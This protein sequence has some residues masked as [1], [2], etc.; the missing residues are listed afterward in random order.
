M[1]FS[2]Y[3]YLIFWKTILHC[4][5]IIKFVLKKKLKTYVE[6]FCELILKG[7]MRFHQLAGI[8]PAETGA[9]YQC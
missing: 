5:T 8:D 4:E 9:L 3:V 1:Y 2:N 6:K 7:K